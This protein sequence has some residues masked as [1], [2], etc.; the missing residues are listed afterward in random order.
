MPGKTESLGI[1]FQGL[2]AGTTAQYSLEMYQEIDTDV[3]GYP[4]YADI[5]NMINYARS[6]QSAFNIF[7]TNK[8]VTTSG[9]DVIVKLPFLVRAYPNSLSYSLTHNCSSLGERRE[10]NQLYVST[11]VLPM[12]NTIV[13]PGNVTIAAL[14]WSSPV[15]NSAGEVTTAPSYTVS[16]NTI[17]FSDTVFGVM[18]IQ[19]TIPEHRY[20]ATMI[21]PKKTVSTA[22]EEGGLNNQITG[23]QPIIMATYLDENDEEHVE[24]LNLTFPNIVDEFLAT[25]P[26]EPGLMV[27]DWEDE[28][29]ETEGKRTLVAL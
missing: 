8:Y 3:L 4:S 26:D 27:V 14:D 19:Y 6:G 29:D 2:S 9:D 15:Y 10:V 18:V 22:N 25:C 24:T 1:S 12:S 5:Q 23:V 11:V 17:I 20:E 16:G 21:I 13:F 28:D 7:R